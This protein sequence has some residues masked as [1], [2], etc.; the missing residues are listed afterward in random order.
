MTQLADSLAK[1]D[2]HRRAGRHQQAE[3]IYRDVLQD[4]PANADTW[5]LLGAACRDRQE[6]AE[7]VAAYRKALELQPAAPHIHNGLG[8]AYACWRRFTDAEISFKR[9]LELK[10][11][12]AKALNN[13]GNALSELR[14]LDEAVEAY[15]QAR[16]LG[17]ADLALEESLGLVLTR[18]GKLDQAE[19]CFR[20]ALVAK[21]ED[22]GVLTRLSI[23]LARQGR[24]D[25]AVDAMRRALRRPKPDA[26]VYLR[27]GDALTEKGKLDLAVRCYEKALELQPNE[28]AVLNHLATARL[29]Q[30]MLDEAA[31]SFRRA[32]AVRADDLWSRSSLLFV[33]TNDPAADPE[34]T[35]EDHV[36]WAKLHAPS[37]AVPPTFPNERNPNRRL[38]IG[39]VSPDFRRHPVGRFVESILA[40]HDKNRVEVFCYDEASR[41][42]DEVG[43]RIRAAAH[44]WR[45]TKDKSHA[46]VANMIRAD[47]IDV[48][49]D[50]AGHTGN[51][52]LGAM[53]LRPAPVQVTYLGYPNTSGL[54]CIDYVLVDAVTQPATEPA[55]FI[56]EPVRLGG[57]FCVYAPRD[58]APLPPPLPAREN[59]HVTFGAFHN[60]SK[61]NAH[62]LALWARVLDA[63][64]GSKLLVGRNT[65]SGETQLELRRRFAAAGIG[66]ERWNCG[67]SWPAR[68]RFSKPIVPWT[69]L[70]THFPGAATPRPAIPSGWACPSS[71][72]AARRT[73]AEWCPAC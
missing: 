59:G 25:E 44:H 27:L 68:R 35:F 64:P 10:P 36:T 50:L 46:E 57:G 22:G 14:K 73:R 4:D 52:R 37:P 16:A 72:C 60:L 54:G 32:L 47:R 6:F 65:L 26:D 21:S 5:C 51:N 55:W 63:V 49:V 69:S 9:A 2:V 13:L 12:Y 17:Y 70:S 66:D 20:K 62:V 71:A 67:C 42:P 56:E 61:V 43:D 33:K 29:Q 1:A 53:A 38:R 28:H 45:M 41:A 18:L 23:V 30:G 39:Y 15:H 40:A 31:V 24:L 19:E 58:D 8:I 7:A 48:L 3:S 34:E 11:D